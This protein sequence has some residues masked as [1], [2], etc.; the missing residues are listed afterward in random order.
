M[1]SPI[2]N[3]GGTLPADSAPSAPVQP[4]R[5]H[6]QELDGVRGFAILMVLALHFLCTQIEAPR[7]GTEA[8]IARVT[9]YGRWGVDLFFVLSGFLITGILYDTRGSRGYFKTFYMRRT[10]RIFPLYYATLLVALV[11]IP[12]GW[13]QQFAPGLLKARASQG[14][15]WPYLTN[16]YVAKQGAFD[17]PYLSHFW[18]LAVEEHFYLVWPFAVGL[19][20][21]RTSMWLSV[22]LSVLAVSLRIAVGFWG[23]NRLYAHVLTPCRLDALCIGA[24]L[25]LAARGPLGAQAI[26]PFARRAV[27]PAA[28][29][30]VLTSLWHAKSPGHVFTEPL[31]ELFLSLFFGFAVVLAATSYGP[32]RFKAWLRV[33]WLRWLGKYSYGLYVF[34]GIVAYSLA[35]HPI[36]PRFEALAGS[37]LGG[38]L[39]QALAG[40]LLS[41][42]IAVLSYEL[43]EA[44][45][46]RL[47]KWFT[48][49]TVALPTG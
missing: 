26:G 20:P 49:S 14:W 29:G 8:L 36:L 35:T 27:L 4:T 30:V 31:R 25:A 44:P 21:R 43:L 18:T 42:G 5:G 19:L 13:L 40:T 37:R 28:L 6:L 1:V 2:A 9:G 33:G 41:M 45:F 24:F 10:L 15:L 16:V 12:A 11:L 17:I 7:S 34:H 22:G 47:K 23:P 38:L 48:P 3:D 46:L 39:L 32:G